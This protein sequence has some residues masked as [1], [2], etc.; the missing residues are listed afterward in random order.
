M[1]HMT[2]R[3]VITGAGA[4]NSIG[5]TQEEFWRN[6]LAGVSGAGPI[7]SRHKVGLRQNVGC[8]VRKPLRAASLPGVG[9]ATQLAITAADNAIADSG[10][11]A[12]DVENADISIGTTMGE[13]EMI[14]SGRGEVC[15]QANAISSGMAKHFH[16]AGHNIT[17]QTACAAGNYAINSAWRRI[18]TGR[19]NVAL[20]GGSD[21]FSRTAFIGFARVGALS[22]DVCRPFDQKRKGLLLGEG[23]GM[24]VLEELE[25]ARHR[26]ANIYAEIL[27][28]G[29]S[30]D[31]FHITQPH[32]KADGGLIAMNRGLKQAGVDPENVDYISAHG[33]GTKFNDLSETVAVKRVFG[34]RRVPISSIKAVIGHTL[35]AASALEAVACCLA[36]RDRVIPP[37]WNYEEPDPECD[38]E[39]VPNCPREANL[40]IIMSNS[41]AFG[42][43]NSSLVLRKYQ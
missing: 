34:G 18:A 42:G 27:G 25:R 39:V 30:C 35:G 22:P 15:V 19:T 20:A 17:W 32:P 41:Y 24:I 12:A 7:D 37:T 33:T 1:D 8:E 28:C 10:L 9:R 21:A 13:P 29:F 6:L 43:T 4:I 11:Q 2:R 36:I 3:V 40:K 31:A 5:L 26:N 16:S 14:D 38:L 23:S